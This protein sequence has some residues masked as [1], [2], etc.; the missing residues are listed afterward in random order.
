MK[1]TQTYTID[2]LIDGC[3]AGNRKVQELLYKQTA[4]KMMVVCMRYAKNRMEAEDVLQMGY[5]KVFQKVKEYRGEGA[6]EGWIRK[7]MVNTAIESYRRNL[8]DLN[9]VQIEEAHEQ[10]SNGFDFS[11]LAMQ[12][13]M[14]IIQKLSDGYRLVFNMYAI[15]GYTHKEIAEVLGISEGASKSQLSR[16]RAILREEIIR[17]GGHKLCIIHR[18]KKLIIYLRMGLSMRRW[19]LLLDFGQL[20]KVSWRSKL[21]GGNF[22]FTGLLQRQLLA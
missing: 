1:L 20:L 17:M 14:Q 4:A 21:L 22:Q 2:E 5:V 19:S 11:R 9:L 7:I 3:K 16:A 18:I 15:E 13:L 8:R 10:P 12:D 6:F